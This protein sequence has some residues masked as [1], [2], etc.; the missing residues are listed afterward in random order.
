MAKGAWTKWTPERIEFARTL[1]AKG[2]S[3]ALI[4]EKLGVSDA[5]CKSAMRKY[6]I[7]IDVAGRSKGMAA[8]DGRPTKKFLRHFLFDRNTGQFTKI[9][10]IRGEPVNQ[11]VDNARWFN[12]YHRLYL[13]N[14]WFYAH[15][16]ALYLETGIWPSDEVDHIN[17]DRSDNRPANLRP[18]TRAQ[19]ACNTAPYN[20]ILKGVTKA[21]DK[22]RA[23]IKHDG[24]IHYL[25]V[26]PTPKLA[27]EAYVRAAKRLHGEFARVS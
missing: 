8:E 13:N 5:A 19:N 10:N 12:G 21:N 3:R 26:Y 1:A 15:R 20:A 4:S 7:K 2:L 9:K 11:V 22:Y 16:V 23:Q 17:G 18:A 25:G 24:K 14:V 27:H 6:G